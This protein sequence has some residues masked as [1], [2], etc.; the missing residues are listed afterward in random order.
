MVCSNE[1]WTANAFGPDLRVFAGPGSAVTDVTAL[2]LCDFTV[3]SPSTFSMWASFM[4]A[5]PHYV[6][7]EPDVVPRIRDFRPT[8]DGLRTQAPDASTPRRGT[9]RVSVGMS[10]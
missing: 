9:A 7:E 4:G 3:G 5:V 6:L 8:I 2:S 1:P 10:E